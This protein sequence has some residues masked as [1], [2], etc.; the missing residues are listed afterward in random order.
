MSPSNLSRRTFLLG[1]AAAATLAAT[2]A[3]SSN[4]KKSDSSGSKTLEKVTYLTGFGKVAREEVIQV[5][6]AKGYFKDAGIE[7]D[8]QPGQPSDANLQALAAGKAQF[9]SVDYVSAVRGSKKYTESDGSPNF[10]VVCAMQKSTLLSLVTLKSKKISK[11]SDLIGK[12]LGAAANAASQTL[13]STYA[14]LAQVDDKQIHWKNFETAQLNGLLINGQLDAIGSYSIDQPGVA[15][16]LKAAGKEDETL[17]L[18]YSEYV[19]DLFGTVIISPTSVTKKKQDLGKRFT[20]ALM[21]GANYAVQ[22]PEEG[23]QIMGKN[24]G[25]DLNVAGATATMKLMA[26]YVDAGDLDPAKV[27]RSIALL[28]NAQMAPAGL[29]P[30]K[31]VAFDLGPSKTS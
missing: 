11:P 29:A 28:E 31:L 1:G 3:C 21:K 14:R 10:Q 9:A 4:D 2:A 7:V 17:A 5:A 24:V 26:P 25:P 8:V 27:M 20:H 12:T 19:T 13:F 22:H 30:E 15:A 16:A 18:P 23:A 6:I